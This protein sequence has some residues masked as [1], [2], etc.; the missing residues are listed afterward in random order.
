MLLMLRL[1]AAAR[2]ADHLSF[3]Y[4]GGDSSELVALI[5]QIA[6][7]EG[8]A[9]DYT[10][11]PSNPGVIAVHFLRQNAAPAVRAPD[12]LKGDF[13]SEGFHEGA[14]ALAAGVTAES[15]RDT[16]ARLIL[17]RAG[18]HGTGFV[19]KD[20]LLV[21]PEGVADAPDTLSVRH[22]SGDVST[23][24][25]KSYAGGVAKLMG[26][27]LDFVHLDE[28][29]PLDIWSECLGRAQSA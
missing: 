20:R 24:A 26:E 1:R 12:E 2:E 8:C 4:G 6:D 18:Q 13:P 17:G 23:L 27:T 28:S 10:V 29:T 21:Q 19:P 15:V 9:I 11:V 5:S 16:I 3:T 14:M 25:F 22:A 7:R